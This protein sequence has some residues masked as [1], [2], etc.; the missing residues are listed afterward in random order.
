MQVEMNS[1]NFNMPFQNFRTGSKVLCW[2]YDTCRSVKNE[3]SFVKFTICIFGILSVLTFCPLLF[4]SRGNRTSALSSECKIDSLECKID[5]TDFAD[6]VT[7]L[8]SKF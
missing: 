5:E 8:P 6:W 4:L 2:Y 3:A 7:F 1:K